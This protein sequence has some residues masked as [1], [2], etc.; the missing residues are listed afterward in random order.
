MMA[1][2][3]DKENR[4]GASGPAYHSS[5]ISDCTVVIHLAANSS[6]NRK[7][8]SLLAAALPEFSIFAVGE[9]VSPEQL[10]E[11]H[12]QSERHPNLYFHNLGADLGKGAAMRAGLGLCKSEYIVFLGNDG[13]VAPESIREAIIALD[14]DKKYDFVIGNR[15]SCNST[16]TVDPFRKIASQFYSFTVRLFFG[17]RTRDVQ[18]PLKVFRREAA[19]A[20][21]S[22]LLLYD[23]GFDAELAFRAK[24]RNLRYFEVSLQWAAR[25]RDWPLGAVGTGL[26]LALVWLRASTS[27]LKHLPF[28]HLLGRRYAIPV[29]SAYRILVFCWRDPKHPEAGGSE[30]YIYEQAIEWIKQGHSVT[31]FSQSFD[32][33]LREETINGVSVVRRGRFLLVFISAPFWYLFRSGRRFDFIIDCMNGFPF[34]TP[35]YST[36]PKVCLL[37]HIHSPHFHEYLPSPLAWL[38]SMVETK[39]APLIYRRTRFITVSESSRTE[40]KESR[41]T[42]LP[43]GIIH[44]GVNSDLSAGEKADAPTILYFGRLKRYKRVHKLIDAFIRIKER[45]PGCK[46]KIAGVGE[47]EEDL[48]R[49]AADAA[50]TDITF[51]GRVSDREKV[52]IMQ[53]AW[54]LG[55]PSSVEG[56]GIVVIEANACA[57]PAVAYRV[58]GLRDCIKDGLTG[59]LATDDD[60]FTLRLLQL[61]TDSDLRNKMSVAADDWAEQFSWSVTAQKTLSEIRRLQPWQAVFEPWESA[62]ADHFITR[63]SHY[64][65]GL[66]SPDEDAL[67]SQK[68]KG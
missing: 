29:Q 66:P 24:R 53:E 38:A 41:I 39:L 67:N 50:V 19:L 12:N 1:S 18:S 31:W 65:P 58:N 22:D 51:L 13:R 25:D 17:L 14:H 30:K 47:A 10:A 36:K 15:W 20:I 43:V 40:M 57:T 42:S 49:Y 4:R 56:W 64:G 34:F 3:N 11:S 21:Y 68:V 6:E 46:L 28:L 27:P 26:A 52:K 33:S 61:L 16:V 59:F 7:Y 23:H 2:G 54:V 48:V 37:H 63:R 55:M 60:E 62:S 44:N 35:L 45:V 8:I 32:G 5:C 9:I